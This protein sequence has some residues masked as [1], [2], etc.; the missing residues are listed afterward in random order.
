MSGRD[1]VMWP[2]LPLLLLGLLRPCTAGGSFTQQCEAA[3]DRT[4][5][6]YSAKTLN[7]SRIVN[8]SDYTGKSVLFVNVATY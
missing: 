4:I 8:F 6:Q 2:V 3:T 7:G 1:G 5:Y